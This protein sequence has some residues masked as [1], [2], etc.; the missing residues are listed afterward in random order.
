VLRNLGLLAVCQGLLLSNGVALIAVNSLLGYQLAASKQLATLPVTTYVIGAALTTLPAS[1]FMKHYGRRAGFTLGAAL[2]MAG[3]GL[4]A[5]AAWSGSFWLLCLGTLLS[6]MYNA[7]GQ[8][9]RFAAADAA[10]L[11]LKSRA[12]SWVLAGG[13]LGGVLGPETSKLTKDLLAP[14]FIGTYGA[15]VLFAALAMVLVRRI[16]LPPLAADEQH[17][18][19]RP[20]AQLA[21]QPAFAVAVLAAVVGYAVMN[22]LMTATPLA[23]DVCRH[24]FPDT[25]FVLEWHVIGMFAP[26]FFTGALIRRFGAHSVLLA[27]AGLMFACAG[28]ALSGVSVMHFW[29][30]LLLLGVGWN[31]LYIGGTTLLTETYRPSEKAK[32]QG[33]NDFLVFA[34]QAAS[35][36]TAGWMLTREGWQMLNLLALPLIALTA[37]ATL[38]LS[39]RRR[40]A[41]PSRP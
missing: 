35:S 36:L 31:F 2:G 26:S 16:E 30:A 18:A 19:G 27:G 5:A 11:E 33:F 4:C 17:Q 29:W 15:L 1:F 28:I 23:M 14:P 24:P 41:S 39:L 10:P 38:W 21:R 13:I 20:L 7:F 37:G 22:L 9:Y 40:G 34:A 12:I 6:G 8:Y 32:A 25:A 3:A